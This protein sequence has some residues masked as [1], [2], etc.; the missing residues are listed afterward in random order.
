M[1]TYVFKFKDVKF[2]TDDG[3]GEDDVVAN[4]LNSRYGK[5]VITIDA[6]SF[7][8]ALS[9]VIYSLKNESGFDVL[10]VDYD[11]TIT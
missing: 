3:Q 11:L 2:K 5:T 4:L 1:P 7:V 8:D 10:D 9:S 6:P